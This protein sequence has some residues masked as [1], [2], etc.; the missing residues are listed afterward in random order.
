MSSPLSCILILFSLR[1]CGKIFCDSCSSYRDLLP[2]QYGLSDP[3][4]VCRQCHSS[5]LPLQVS[6]TQ[7]I[8]NHQKRNSID[9][10]GRCVANFMNMPYSSTLE[11]EIRKA[12]YST[13]NLFQL[14]YIKDKAIPLRLISKAYGLAFLTVAKAGIGIGGKFGTGLVVARL[15]NG[16]WSAPCAIGTVGVIWG[17]LAGADLTDY[18]VVLNAPEALHA[19][20]RVGQLSI[21]AD[22]DV[23]IGPIGR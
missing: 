8:A 4:R 18:V 5:L 12:A 15:Q 10:S 19:F 23:A 22:I 14:K 7:S 17:M 3:Q 6:L 21:G 20:A 13:Y 16:H 1:H 11:S 2:H 9:K